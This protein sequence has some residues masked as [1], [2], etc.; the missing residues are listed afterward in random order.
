LAG[1]RILGTLF[2]CLKK[3]NAQSFARDLSSAAGSVISTLLANNGSRALDVDEELDAL[4][5][6]G[7]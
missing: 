5:L 4:L 2:F 1:S 3:W 7:V 6:L